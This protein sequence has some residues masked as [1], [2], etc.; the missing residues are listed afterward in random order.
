M[1]NNSA[2]RRSR[3]LPDVTGNGETAPWRTL[4]PD[5]QLVDDFIT[6][7]TLERGMSAN[8]CEA[9][10]RDATRAAEYFTMHS[11][12]LAD[13]CHEDILCLLGYLDD[14]GIG[15][16]SQARVMAGVRSFF[17]YLLIEGYIAADPMALIESPNIGIHLPEV[18][19]VEEI[20]AMIAAIDPKQRYA[21]RNNAIIETIYGS[22]LRVSELTDLRI[23]RLNLDEGYAIVDGKGSKQRIVPLSPVAVELIRSY[24]EERSHGKIRPRAEDCL[25]ISRQG[26]PLTRVMVFYIVRDLAAAAGITKEVSPHTLRHSFAT[27]LLEGGASL[28]VIQELLGHE[29][30]ATTEI[31]V[32]VDN[33]RLRH[34]LLA[35]HP[36]FAK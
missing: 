23:S 9:Y 29:S 26:K 3:A 17:R 20:N 12:S 16:R 4:K 2:Y 35:H 33:T 36:H 30:I 24:L 14:L 22:G 32:H 13:V 10:R 11:I 7:L 15:R 1:T 28:R 5:A 6:Y 31:Y 25:F 18:L 21:L 27:H 34:E 19:D 8:T